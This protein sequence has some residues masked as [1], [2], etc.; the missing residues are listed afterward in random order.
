LPVRA[1]KG[2]PALERAD[3]M[4]K[5]KRASR[6]ISRQHNWFLLRLF[7]RVFLVCPHG[8]SLRSESGRAA[9][10]SGDMEPTLA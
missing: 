7:L 3:V 4:A 9:G 10:L 6:A 1:L 2:D 5:M 8:V